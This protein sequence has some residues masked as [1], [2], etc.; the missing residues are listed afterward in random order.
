M[1][2]AFDIGNVLCTFDIHKFVKDLYDEYYIDCK[3]SYAFLES[4]QHIHDIGA[5]TMCTAFENKYFV[6]YN[7]TFSVMRNGHLSNDEI[8]HVIK[9]WNKIIKPADIMLNL[10]DNLRSDGVKISLLSNMGK[11]HH[12]YLQEKYPELFNGT[13]QHISYQV[14]ARKPSKLFYQSFLLDNEE[15][16]GASYIDDIE[17]N[18]KVAKKYS[19]K[20]YNF[21]LKK[22]LEMPLSKQKTEVDKLRD[23]IMTQ[24]L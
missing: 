21:D 18:C 6:R 1:H 16:K 24:N 15:F 13:V 9:M 12:M 19:F 20:V 22:V 11:D 3:C 4:I 5:V 7:D 8:Y 23:L 2:V 17:E 14:G 10:L